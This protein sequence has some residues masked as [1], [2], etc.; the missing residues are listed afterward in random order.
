MSRRP[1]SRA[2]HRSLYRA[3]ILELALPHNKALCCT[4][5][6]AMLAHGAVCSTASSAII[7]HSLLVCGTVY[8]RPTPPRRPLL[9]S[10]PWS[11]RRRMT[12][13]VQTSLSLY[14]SSSVYVCLS[15]SL[16]RNIVCSDLCGRTA[17]ALASGPCRVSARPPC[18]Q[19]GSRS[20]SQRRGFD[21]TRQIIA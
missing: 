6:E 13:S 3:R 2:L 19:N 20:I 4:D 11:P 12:G 8:R 9:S 15:V 7:A 17:D 1:H 10:S 14:T 5:S 16:L 21:G 18:A